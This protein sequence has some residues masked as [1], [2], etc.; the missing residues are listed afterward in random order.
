MQGGSSINRP[1]QQCMHA[2]LNHVR[3]TGPEAMTKKLQA[4]AN[5]QFWKIELQGS[6][7][8]RY[9][10][11]SPLMSEEGDSACKDS[12]TPFLQVFSTYRRTTWVFFPTNS[13][14]AGK[15]SSWLF[16]MDND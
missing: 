13:A 15:G 4:L 14:K 16:L 9:T 8:V 6:N 1:D 7:P 2:N 10:S 12:Q 5:F 11:P 3:V